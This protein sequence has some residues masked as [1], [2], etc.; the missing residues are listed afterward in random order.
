MKKSGTAK[1]VLLLFMIFAPVFSR[2]VFSAGL[3]LEDIREAAVLASPEIKKLET[4]KQNQALAKMAYYFKYIPSLSA[5]AS[6]AYSPF[7]HTQ[8]SALDSLDAGAAFSINGK[9]NIFDG[10]KSKAERASL[11]LEDSA[12]DAQTQARLF[13][14]LEEADN[15]YFNCL[16]AEAA[17]KT[18]ELQAEISSLALE[19]AE[20]RRAGGILSPSDYYL[21]LSNKSAA[22]SS[23]AAAQTALALARRRLEQFTGNAGTVDLLPLDFENYEE[24]LT[25]ISRWTIEDI[26]GRFLKLKEVLASR[27]PALKSAYIALKQAENEY[28]LTKSAFLP[29]LNLSASFNLNYDFTGSPPAGPLSSNASLSLSGTIPLD[30]WNL[31][32]GEQRQKN[33]L[34]NSRIDYE[35]TLAGF[36]IDLQSQLFTLAGNAQTLVANRLQAEYSALLLEQQRELFR[37][38]SVSMTS[39]LDAASRSLSGETQKTRAEFSFLRSLSALKTLGA[40]GDEELLRLLKE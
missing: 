24:L 21:A 6:A 19:T 5:S 30:Y 12:L 26:S 15:R 23:L 34:E 10:G 7:P 40:F 29:S 3:G 27:S 2:T 18:A 13:A 20:I 37:L 9:I 25:A 1:I 4:V 39:F 35:N 22:D 8:A 36:D 16:E 28:N 32:N 38:S 14:V 31:I 11:S 17:I 33:S